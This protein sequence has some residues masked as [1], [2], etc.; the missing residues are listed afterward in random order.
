[1]KKFPAAKKEQE[2]GFYAN[3]GTNFS[4]QLGLENFI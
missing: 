4:L 1:M 3:T 2:H